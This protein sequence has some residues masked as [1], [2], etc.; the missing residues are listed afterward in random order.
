ME[1]K[2]IRTYPLHWPDGWPRTAVREDAKFHRQ[3]QRFRTNPTGTTEYTER[4]R[5]S[6]GDGCDRVLRALGAMGIADYDVVISTNIEPTL[7][8]VPRRAGRAP[9]DPGVALYWKRKGKRQCMAIDRYTRV[10]DNLAAVAATLDAMRSIDRHGGAQILDRAFTGFV[11]LP[12]PEQWFQVLGVS[13]GASIGQI[14]DAYRDLASKHHPDKG[15]DSNEMARINAAR[16]AG[17]EA[18]R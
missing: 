10:G 8:G 13:A 2:S 4:E 14:Q 17:M 1:E 3:T 6:I 12:A 7:S 18:R 11:A 16:D 5:L 9:D 15:G